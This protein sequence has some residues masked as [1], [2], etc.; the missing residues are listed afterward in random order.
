MMQNLSC[1]TKTVSWNSILDDT[2]EVKK[3]VISKIDEIAKNLYKFQYKPSSVGALV[4]S[5]GIALFMYYYWLW[6]ERDIFYEKSLEILS[7]CIDYCTRKKVINTFCDGISGLGWCLKLL[8]KKDIVEGNVNEII[9]NINPELYSEMMYM[10]NNGQY[11]FLHKALGIGLYYKDIS[12]NYVSDLILG[13]E[14]SA[15]KTENGVYWYSTYENNNISTDRAIN[16]SMSHGLASIISFLC[17]LSNQNDNARYLLYDAVRFML[18]QQQDNKIYISYFPSII[19]ETIKHSSNRL[20]WCYGDLGIAV[21]LWYASCVLDNEKYHEL[22]LD[23]FVACCDR[24]NIKK[25][26]VFDAGICHGSSGI[27]HIFNR[28]YQHTGNIR[29]KDAAIFWIND[30]LRKASFDDGLA[31]YKVWRT[32]GWITQGGILEGIA[33]IG[34]VLLSAVSDIEP[35]WDECLLLS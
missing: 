18:S 26:L 24:R 11:D 17:K 21:S 35:D 7:S 25:E 3:D 19:C 33:G 22:A 32:D 9:E 29:L 34:L 15:V 14:R 20:A 12:G 8:S 5:P 6:S 2:A 28:M 13:L 31:G 1:R 27:A 23:V 10:I 4:G 16:L 30:C